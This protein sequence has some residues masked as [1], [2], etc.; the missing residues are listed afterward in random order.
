M[1]SHAGVRAY[2][3]G[4]AAKSG[5]VTGVVDDKRMQH[6]IRSVLGDVVDFNGN[7]NVLAP[8]G[9]GCRKFFR[10]AHAQPTWTR[11]SSW[12]CQPMLSKTSMSWA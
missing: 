2:Y 9:H 10:T 1:R 5:D 7:G 4:D 8:V 3:A 12:A 11:P 6:A